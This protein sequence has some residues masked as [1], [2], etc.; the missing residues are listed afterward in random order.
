MKKKTLWYEDKTSPWYANADEPTTPKETNPW[1]A[2]NKSD[3]STN[4]QPQYATNK[5]QLT[6]TKAEPWFAD[7]IGQWCEIN[8]ESLLTPTKAKHWYENK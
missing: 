3:N 8:K 5:D 4:I 6:F 2:D 1:Y 7:N